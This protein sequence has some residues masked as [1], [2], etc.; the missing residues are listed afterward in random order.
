MENKEKY[1][2]FSK[3]IN[4]TARYK[5]AQFAKGKFELS[6]HLE[7]KLL[8]WIEGKNRFF[9][10]SMPIGGGK[11]YFCSALMNKF[12][13]DEDIIYTD[14][15]EIKFKVYE[16]EKPWELDFYGIITPSLHPEIDE[17]FSTEK[18]LIIEDIEQGNDEIWTQSLIQRLIDH[19]YT[20]MLPT[21]ITTSLDENQFKE[22]MGGYVTSRIRAKNNYYWEVNCTSQRKLGL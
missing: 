15:L 1:I 20:S 22:K 4:Q 18:I 6:P 11:T 2:S 21:L 5:D 3:K 7:R 19:R 17:I 12:G 8:E 9:V 13:N 14:F 16:K 10:L